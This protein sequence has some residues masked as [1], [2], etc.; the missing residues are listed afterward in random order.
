MFKM[1]IMKMT[2]ELGKLIQE[3]A[4][5]KRMETAKEANDS[6]IALQNQI[7]E[8]NLVRGELS[9]AMQAEPKDEEAVAAFDEKLKG[10]YASVMANTNMIE[11]DNAKQ[12]IDKMMNN[13]TN[14]LMMSVNGE[15]PETCSA[16]PESCGGS[17]SSCSG[18]H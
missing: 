4:E 6:D 15:D 14:I 3:S 7:E 17:C 9:T 18:C 12:D 13:I 2:R 11:F 8:F 5:Y 10:I 1:A 16:E